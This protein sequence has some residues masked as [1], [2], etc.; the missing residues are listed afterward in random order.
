MKKPNRIPILT[1]ILIVIIPI[2]SCK[3]HASGMQ[4]T[5]VSPSARCSSD[6]VYDSH[7]ERVILFGGLD[8]GNIYG[9]TWVYDH[10]TNLWSE[11]NPTTHPNAR[12]SISLVY[13]SQNSIILLFGGH[14]GSSWLDETWVFDCQTD[15]WSQVFPESSPPARGSAGMVYDSVNDVV[16]LF[17][18]Y[19]SFDDTWI[20]DYSTTTW[21]EVSTT[22][23]PSNRYGHCMTYDE[24]R[25]KT[26]LFSG[27]SI[28][29]MRS[30]VWEF[31]YPCEIWERIDDTTDPLGRKWGDMVYDSENQVQ[32]LFSGDCNDPEFVN[33]LWIYNAATQEWSE[34]TQTTRP[35][36]RSS[37]TMIYDS[38]NQRV[39][40]FGGH[41]RDMSDNYICFGDTWKY[42]Y[43]SNIW[44]DMETE[45]TSSPTETPTTLDFPMDWTPVVLALVCGIPLVVLFVAWRKKR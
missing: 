35:Q 11:L 30:D 2:T 14:D 19:E 29:G 24:D 7:N 40:L 18:G 23:N 36:A 22:T 4:V 20:F 12:H 31:D 27:N 28:D 41:G 16:I 3:F 37:T 25:D 5:W 42:D 34:L 44:S 21:T 38:S 45:P 43:N 10:S 39:I 13:D 32:I 8:A 33:D 1:I 15:E 6:M 9:D 17:G 26:V